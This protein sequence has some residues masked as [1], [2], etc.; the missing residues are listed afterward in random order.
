MNNVWIEMMQSVKTL[1][2][3]AWKPGLNDCPTAEALFDYDQAVMEGLLPAEMSGE[4]KQTALHLLQCHDCAKRLEAIRLQEVARQVALSTEALRQN[5]RD[6]GRLLAILQDVSLPGWLSAMAAD[7]LTELGGTQV[8]QV[9]RS[10]ASLDT[11]SEVREAAADALEQLK[12]QESLR[13][14]IQQ[15]LAGAIQD[16]RL[17]VTAPLRGLQQPG[18]LAASGGQPAISEGGV[19][20]EGLQWQLTKDQQGYWLGLRLE[21]PIQTKMVIHAF[22]FGH[23]EEE[24]LL[25]EQITLIPNS[26]E[27]QSARAFLAQDGCLPEETF[28]ILGCETS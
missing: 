1:E 3:K 11:D 8:E 5:A 26:S 20:P 21:Q 24:M 17:L 22:V 27:F 6:A 28:F 7:Y 9:L 23:D 12:P 10:V 16:I 4:R 13:Q 18:T 15:R 2:A 25:H 19:T 14:M